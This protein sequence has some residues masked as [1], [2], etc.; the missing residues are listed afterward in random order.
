M[1]RASNRVLLRAGA[2]LLVL[3]PLVLWLCAGG[4][5]R[6]ALQALPPVDRQTIFVREL[7]TF[8]ALCGPARRTD[9]LEDRCRERAGFLLE[10]PECGRDCRAQVEAYVRAATR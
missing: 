9:A 3:A 6:G 5:E 10:F 8:R 7:E 2:V 1:T 4:T